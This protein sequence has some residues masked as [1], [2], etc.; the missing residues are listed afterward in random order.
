LDADADLALII[1]SYTF[2]T[3]VLGGRMTLGMMSARSSSKPVVASSA[4]MN[5]RSIRKRLRPDDD[6]LHAA[7]PPPQS[8]PPA[9]EGMYQSGISVCA[10]WINSWRRGAASLVASLQLFTQKLRCP[11][12]RA[13]IA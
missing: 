11:P 6:R 10:R 2:E 3:P 7:C 13:G 8:I 12:V 9:A 4:P 1:P 5:F